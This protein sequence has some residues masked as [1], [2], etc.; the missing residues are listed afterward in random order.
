MLAL[1][2]LLHLAHLEVSVLL[3]NP[4]DALLD[5]HLDGPVLDVLQVSVLLAVLLDGLVAVVHLLLELLQLQPHVV[6][7]VIHLLILV[8]AALQILAEG[9]EVDFFVV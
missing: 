7:L 6:Q 1:H 4:P 5:L 9:L 3:V 8:G 2:G